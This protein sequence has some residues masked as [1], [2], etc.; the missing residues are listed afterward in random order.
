MPSQGAGGGC[1]SWTF[2]P[3][4]LM[5]DTHRRDGRGALPPFAEPRSR[6]RVPVVDLSSSPA[7]VRTAPPDG[8]GALPSPPSPFEVCQCGAKEPA[9]GAEEKK[10]EQAGGAVEVCGTSLPF[11][12]GAVEPAGAAKRKKEAAVF[13]AR[14]GRAQGELRSAEPPDPS[15]LEP[16]SRR[17]PRKERRRRRCSLQEAGGRKAERHQGGLAARQVGR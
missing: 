11:G 14:G 13:T 17:A 12:L 3:L 7:H 5:S 16:W 6:R 2:P 10:E 15:A 1:R 4:L 8:R 9:A